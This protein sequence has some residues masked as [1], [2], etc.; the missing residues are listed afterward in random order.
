MDYPVLGHYVW[1]RG[2]GAIW[3]SPASRWTMEMWRAYGP[4]REGGRHDLTDSATIRRFTFR[5]DESADRISCLI[6]GDWR[7]STAPILKPGKH[8][9][10]SIR[11]RA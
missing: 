11:N 10:P 9:S 4:V 5:G 2:A 7:L 1:R 3:T 8:R 6:V